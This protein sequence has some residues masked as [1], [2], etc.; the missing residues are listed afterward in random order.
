MVKLLEI[1]KSPNPTKKFRAAFMLD[2]GKIKHIDFGAA[3]YQDYTLTGDK[4]A[5]ARYQNRHVKDLETPNNRIGLGAG[6]LSFYTLWGPHR[7]M[8]Q[9]IM[10]YKKLFN[11]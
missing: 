3:R 11:L 9:N 8:S 6:A 5:R 1:K 4:D 2:S 10:A 7:S